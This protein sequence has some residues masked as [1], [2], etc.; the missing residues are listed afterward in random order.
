MMISMAIKMDVLFEFSCPLLDFPRYTSTAVF[1]CVIVSPSVSKQVDVRL[2]C[3][4]SVHGPAPYISGRAH[5]YPPPQNPQPPFHDVC[6]HVWGHHILFC[7]L[8][9][10]QVHIHVRIQATENAALAIRTHICLCTSITT[11]SS[12]RQHLKQT[13]NRSSHPRNHL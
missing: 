8:K 1:V 12:T 4:L 9:V 2:I 5:W 6:G 10:R 7:T 3:G 11:K 13:K